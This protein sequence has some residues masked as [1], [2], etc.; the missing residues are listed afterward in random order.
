MDFKYIYTRQATDYQRM[1][2]AEDYEENLRA[3]LTQIT[4]FQ[5]KR[6][7]DLGSGTGRIPLLLAGHGA[8]VVGLDLHRAMLREQQVQQVHV[9][10]NWP[11]VQGD[12]RQLPFADAAA[13]VVVA[14]W[15]IG[16][17]CG[18]YPQNW[19]E[20]ITQVLK[21]MQRVAAVGG[22]LVIIETLT[23]GSLTP[24]PP[25]AALA[26]YY[27]WLEE[28]KGFTRQTLRTD[29]QF[30]SVEAAVAH[31]AFFFGEELAEMIRRNQWQRLPEWT[32]VWIRRV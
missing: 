30:A 17:L 2:A 9:G 29:Y 4:P 6:V 5:G 14:G 31:T 32:G 3:A 1:I 22:T 24:A 25:T 26:A 8:A 27:A 11:L 20:Q 13:E 7:L 21:E 16:H 10:G 12:I 28:E 19:Q 23:T 15:A 18:W